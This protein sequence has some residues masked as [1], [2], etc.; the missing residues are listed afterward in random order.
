[1]QVAT[2]TSK[3]ISRSGSAKNRS[4]WTLVAGFS[5]ESIE[6]DSQINIPNLTAELKTLTVWYKNKT[7][8]VA[9]ADFSVN[10]NCAGG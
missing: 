5:S 6:I 9:I 4:S 8:L 3:K 7:V 1:M 10:D 2:F